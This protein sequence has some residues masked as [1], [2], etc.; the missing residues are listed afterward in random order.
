MVQLYAVVPM[1]TSWGST[2]RG[3]PSGTGS[4][5]YWSFPVSGLMTISVWPDVWDGWGCSG[6][7]CR[8]GDG[9]A[10]CSGG[11]DCSG[12]SSAGWVFVSSA[13]GEGFG[14]SSAA[15]SSGSGTAEGACSG[16]CTGSAVS[17]VSS[18]STDWDVS[19]A[20]TVQPR[21]PGALPPYQN[22]PANTAAISTGTSIFHLC[23]FHHITGSPY[24]SLALSSIRYSISAISQRRMAREGS[25]FSAL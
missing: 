5:R 2:G 17:C 3:L 6:S 18:S 23:C 15:V 25:T 22:A 7:G 4:V 20:G 13:A 1:V 11:A 19:L 21:A 16:V 9:A 24:S 8:E 14:V 10:V 12:G